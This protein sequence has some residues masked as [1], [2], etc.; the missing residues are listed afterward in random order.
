MP[1]DIKVVAFAQQ[2]FRAVT[3]KDASVL[4]RHPLAV[5]LTHTTFLKNEADATAFGT[6]VLDLRKLDRWTWV[7]Q[8]VA[9]NYAT[10]ELGDT[11]T[12]VHPRFGL[13]AGKNFIVKG[14]KKDTGAVLTSLI[15]FGPQT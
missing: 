13:Q 3:A 5:E 6:Q 10:L 8:V 14:I 9:D 12:V 1:V 2:E 7:C 4:T 15:L 11:I